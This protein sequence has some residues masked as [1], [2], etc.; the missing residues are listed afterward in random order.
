MSAILR[1]FVLRNEPN[2]NALWQFLKNNWRAL[3]GAGKPLA[4]TVQEHKTKRSTDQ[5]KRYWAI[6]NEIAANT[7]SRTS[8]F[9]PPCDHSTAGLVHNVGGYTLIGFE[10]DDRLLPGSVVA[11]EVAER[12]MKAAA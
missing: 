10:T 11:E 1:T 8:G 2:A 6:L 12:A 7:E 9:C 5:N 4:V 3:A